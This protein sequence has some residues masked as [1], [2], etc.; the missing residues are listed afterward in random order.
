MARRKSPSPTPALPAAGTA[1]RARRTAVRRATP[2]SAPAPAPAPAST[3]APEVRSGDH[4]V[5]TTHAEVSP[6]ERIRMRAYFLHLERKGRPADPLGDWLRAEHEVV[7][8]ADGSA[9]S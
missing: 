2:A 1:P 9:Q 4:D 6:A 7:V 8:G 5:P 3:V